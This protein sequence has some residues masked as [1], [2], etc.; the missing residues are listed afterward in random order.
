MSKKIEIDPSIL[1]NLTR[2]A[3]L[4]SSMGIGIVAAS[5][6]LGGARSLAKDATSAGVPGPQS[7]PN[8]GKLTTGHFPARA[9]HVRN[10]KT[11]PDAATGSHCGHFRLTA[12]GLRKLADRMVLE[13]R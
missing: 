13:K 5:K 10:S 12:M 11:R 7:G 3:M 6:L 4:S 2:R 9:K 1:A 8:L